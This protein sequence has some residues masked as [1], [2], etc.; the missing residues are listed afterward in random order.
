VDHG[1]P[2]VHFDIERLAGAD[3]A[4]RSLHEKSTFVVPR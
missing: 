4:P 2:T 3:Q 1:A